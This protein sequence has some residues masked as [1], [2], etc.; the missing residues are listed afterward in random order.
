MQWHLLMIYFQKL[1]RY[2]IYKNN[3]FIIF[4]L[5]QDAIIFIEVAD[6]RMSKLK[7]KKLREK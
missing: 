3:F 2:K 7:Y 1:Y 5:T 4:K 6:G